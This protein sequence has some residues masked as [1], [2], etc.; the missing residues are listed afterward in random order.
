MKVIHLVLGKA[1]PERMNGVN[2]VAHH[3]AMSFYEL[4]IPVEI[5]G[6]TR[7]PDQAVYPRPFPTYLFRAQP[8]YRDLDPKL[9]YAISQQE[10]DTV[11]HIHGA[12]ITD[13]YKVTRLLKD[14]KL[15][16]VYTPHGAFNRIALEKNK[17]VK[18]VY[19]SQFEKAILRDA[20]KVQFLGQSE[21]DHIASVVRLQNKVVIP[22]GQ[23][24]SELHFDFS[25]MQRRRNPVF[26]FCGRLDIYYKGLD[27]L[28]EGFAAYCRKEG[29]GELWLIGDGPDRPKL[30]ALCRQ[31]RISERVQ[32]MGARYGKDKLNR[33]ANMD[34]FCHPSRSEGSPTAVLE[35]GALGRTLM[36]S[37]ATNVGQQVEQYRCGLHLRQSNAASIEKALFDFEKYYRQGLHTEMGERAREMV[38]REFNWLAVARRL[39]DVYQVKNA[40]LR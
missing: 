21:F 18:K 30:E 13:F 28:L 9:M 3:L 35:A 40:V 29:D 31:L 15:A 33:I 36:V 4:Q 6:I 12:F 37:T 34:L 14:M 1:N 7:T 38:S 17:W 27:T 8:I 25:N 26:G 19:I 2:K 20:L 39:L 16:Y 24:F 22:N 32:F 10:K 11:F 5:W 23:D